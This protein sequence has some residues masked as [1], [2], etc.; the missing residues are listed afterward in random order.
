MVVGKILGVH[1]IADH[2]HLRKQIQT[3]PI[4][5]RITVVAVDLVVGFF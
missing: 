5:I 4:P 1:A 2:I 3:M